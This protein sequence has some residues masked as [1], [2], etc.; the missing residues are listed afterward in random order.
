VARAVIAR[1]MAA[2]SVG[3]TRANPDSSR[4]HCVL[5]LTVREGTVPLRGAAGHGGGAGDPTALRGLSA[6][7]ASHHFRGGRLIGKATFVDL[8]GSE[9]AHEA[10]PPDRTTAV[11]AAEI[12]KSLLALKECI[13]AMARG[14]RL[15]A[16]HLDAGFTAAG[17][18]AG[19]GSDRRLASGSWSG[20]GSDDSDG[21][22]GARRG[23]GG[24]GEG[25]DPSRYAAASGSGG[26]SGARA[27][28]SGPARRPGTASAAAAIAAAPSSMGAL[29]RPT[30]SRSSARGRRAG[31]GGGGGA[32]HTHIPF[33]GSKLTQ[34]LRDCFTCPGALTVM[35]ATVAPGSGCADH[36]LNT[37]RYAD[38]LKEISVQHAAV[39]TAAGDGVARVGAGSRG[40]FIGAASVAE[41]MGTTGLTTVPLAD[42]IAG[43]RV[44]VLWNAAGAEVQPARDGAGT[45][46]AAP[47]SGDRPPAAPPLPEQ[48]FCDVPLRPAGEP[49]MLAFTANVP[50]SS[51]TA[52]A[53]RTTTAVAPPLPPS[54]PHSSTGTASSWRTLPTAAAAAPSPPLA[55]ASSVYMASNPAGAA[56]AAT[57]SGT[58]AAAAAAASAL[59]SQAPSS[60]SQDPATLMAFLDS[61]ISHLEGLRSRVR[62]MASVR[63]SDAV[64]AGSSAPGR[65]AR[66]ATGSPDRPAAAAASSAAAPLAVAPPQAPPA[67]ALTEGRKRAAGRGPAAATTAAEAA[68]SGSHRLPVA[69]APDPRAAVA[70]S[71]HGGGAGRDAAASRATTATLSRTSRGANPPAQVASG[72]AAASS[73]VP[74]SGRGTGAGSATTIPLAPGDT[75]LEGVLVASPPPIKRV[76]SRAAGSVAA[77][78]G[79][80]PDGGASDGAPIT[81]SA[82]PASAPSQLVRGSSLSLASSSAAASSAKLAAAKWTLS[83]PRPVV[84]YGDA[85]ESTRPPSALQLAAAAA[86]E[87]RASGKV[88]ASAEADPSRVLTHHKPA[89]PVGAAAPFVRPSDGK[90]STAAAAAGAH[91]AAKAVSTGH[92]RRDDVFL[93]GAIS[94]PAALPTAPPAVAKLVSMHGGSPPQGLAGGASSRYSDGAGLR[95]APPPAAPLGVGAGA[96]DKPTRKGLTVSSSVASGGAPGAAAVTEGVGRVAAIDK[97]HL[98]HHRSAAAALPARHGGENAAPLPAATLL[99]L[100]ARAG[101]RTGVAASSGGKPGKA[102]GGS[103]G[104]GLGGLSAAAAAPL[105]VTGGVVWG[106]R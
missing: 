36:S 4:S 53:R 87:A 6:V 40:A 99:P 82:K 44:G 63:L 21:G 51:S 8:A 56:R 70:P 89:Q 2:R 69:P 106:L 12:N 60:T 48:L 80:S 76:A 67:P 30:R 45:A 31:G 98:S 57:A 64:V 43:W 18:A 25:Y 17:A 7:E 81:L 20:D 35:I 15:P 84:V 94:P 13:R 24:M 42:N 58:I 52:A 47:P 73:A 28:S 62:G 90:R 22:G 19:G 50:S 93:R 77:P 39:L 27:R 83:P 34:I 61:Q 96:P 104:A 85:A 78:A 16:A 1:G 79:R 32:P 86:R 49:R 91:G 9:Q 88:P 65:A 5:Q 66:G 41:G 103:G 37:L 97:S 100:D 3:V 95:T 55:G 71:S 33:R 92:L 38:R 11:E 23:G 101:G 54:V 75:S 29:Q 102:T 105:L 68:D 26:G 10:A 14:F 59:V 46:A 74:V 72:T